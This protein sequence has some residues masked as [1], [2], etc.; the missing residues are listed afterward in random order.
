MVKYD[1]FSW[2]AEDKESC[3][4]AFFRFAV[5]N[6]HFF[7]ND[8]N[9][10]RIQRRNNNLKAHLSEIP[11]PQMALSL[12]PPSCADLVFMEDLRALALLRKAGDF[13]RLLV[14]GE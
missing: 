1:A 3:C 5:A 14:F 7:G 2:C 9:T 11:P 12:R 8:R 4:S 13:E 10:A 6:H